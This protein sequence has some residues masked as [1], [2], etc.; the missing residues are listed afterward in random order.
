MNESKSSKPLWTG[1]LQERSKR[2]LQ[3][4]EIES[5]LNRRPSSGEREP[6]REG[7]GGGTIVLR[8]ANELATLRKSDGRRRRRGRPL[9]KGESLAE[10]ARAKD[11]PPSSPMDAA[12]SAAAVALIS[13]TT[14]L[15]PSVATLGRL[16]FQFQRL[17]RYNANVV[18][19]AH[20]SIDV[21][22]RSQAWA[23]K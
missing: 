16:L 5:L 19:Q 1:W 13:A 20:S 10:G 2:D 4:A 12:V 7:E 6:L 22:C 8:L 3:I 11:T 21:P 18:N 17:R 15:A 23:T 14:T 9:E